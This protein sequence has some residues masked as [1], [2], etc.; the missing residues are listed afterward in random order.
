MKSVGYDLI[1][2]LVLRGSS[3]VAMIESMQLEADVIDSF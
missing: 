2:F 3:I 1:T